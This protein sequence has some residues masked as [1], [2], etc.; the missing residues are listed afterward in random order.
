MLSLPLKYIS[1]SS[2]LFSVSATPHR[3]LPRPPLRR[4]YDLVGHWD[5]QQSLVDEL[6]SNVVHLD[7]D[8]RQRGTVVLNKPYGLPLNKQDNCPY[9]LKESLKELAKR[10]QLDQKLILVKAPE[11]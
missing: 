2:R 8:G 7:V 10:L 9:Y 5:S 3:E 1:L 6:E 4:Q 11:R